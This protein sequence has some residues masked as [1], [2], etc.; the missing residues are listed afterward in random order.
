MRILRQNPHSIHRDGFPANISARE[1]IWWNATQEEFLLDTPIFTYGNDIFIN[2]LPADEVHGSVSVF[3]FLVGEPDGV[4]ANAGVPQSRGALVAGF[5]DINNYFE[6]RAVTLADLNDPQGWSAQVNSAF[7]T[8]IPTP[9]FPQA[10]LIPPTAG[11]VPVA[12]DY[13]ATPMRL[14]LTQ[15]FALCRAWEH[16]QLVQVKGGDETILAEEVL[17]HQLQRFSSLSQRLHMRLSVVRQ[18]GGAATIIGCYQIED[19]LNVIRHFFV[20]AEVDSADCGDYCGTRS[21]F[22]FYSPITFRCLDEFNTRFVPNNR[23][24]ASEGNDF[25]DR[26]SDQSLLSLASQSTLA[27]GFDRNLQWLDASAGEAAWRVFP[28]LYHGSKASQSVLVEND[29]NWPSWSMVPQAPRTT[30]T[31]RFRE[32]LAPQ[33]RGGYAEYRWFLQ[34]L[35]PS[36]E[37]TAVNCGTD[38]VFVGQFSNY[39]AT[40]YPLALGKY[41]PY[42]LFGNAG[43]IGTGLNS[44]FFPD[45]GEPISPQVV[46]FGFGP[47]ANV[48]VSGHL[49]LSVHT[50]FSKASTITDRQVHEWYNNGLFWLYGMASVFQVPQSYE[51]AL[52]GMFDRNTFP[53]SEYERILADVYLDKNPTVAGYAGW[54]VIE[55]YS[56]QYSDG[57][58]AESGLWSPR[59]LESPRELQQQPVAFVADWSRQGSGTGTGAGGG[60]GGSGPEYVLSN[61][62]LPTN[63]TGDLMRRWPFAP[64]AWWIEPN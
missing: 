17:P 2:A 22:D 54:N 26:H 53:A 37:M 45:T 49:V 1:A 41:T 25:G 38:L 35:P 4:Y 43:G 14:G 7:F 44:W 29:S 40:R 34:W 51:G 36:L 19:D 58:L 21:F 52:D 55:G 15:R 28:T 46:E 39:V 33:F 24:P 64:L 60:S 3:D 10:T 59:L 50:Q 57:G 31:L 12:Y 56:G 20:Q 30:L 48:A 11:G 61:Y 13:V 32:V 42:G 9:D 63:N 6:L 47:A 8:D 27:S 5:K 23:K 18:L 62:W 16:L